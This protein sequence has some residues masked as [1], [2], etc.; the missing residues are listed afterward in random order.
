MLPLGAFVALAALAFQL[1]TFRLD[2][3]GVALGVPVCVA[4]PTSRL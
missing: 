3:S 4:R 1:D 2:F